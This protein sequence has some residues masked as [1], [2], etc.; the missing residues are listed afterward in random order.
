MD[1]RTR[2][3]TGVGAYIAAG[4]HEEKGICALLVILV[5]KSI[6]L[7]INLTLSLKKYCKG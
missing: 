3:D 7:H 2:A 1:E 5:K 6:A 4:N